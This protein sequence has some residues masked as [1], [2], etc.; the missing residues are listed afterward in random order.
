MQNMLKSLLMKINLFNIFSLNEATKTIKTMFYGIF[1]SSTRM[2]IGATSALYLISHGLTIAEIGYL[3]AVQAFIILATDLP[4]GYL[5]DQYSR[6]LS[7][8]LGVLF[9]ASWLGITA[10]APTKEWFY[11]AEI[12]NALSIALFNGAY[13]AILVETYKKDNNKSDLSALF[14]SYAKYNFLFMAIA[15]AIGSFFSKINSPIFWI[16]GAALLLLQLLFFSDFI[17]NDVKKTNKKRKSIFYFYKKLKK[18]SKRI[19][20]ELF[21]I[22]KLSI[23][24]LINIFLGIYYQIFIQYWQ[25]I[26][27]IWQNE[28]DKST[29]F[30]IIFIGILLI[31]SLAGKVI[32]GIIKIRYSIIIISLLLIINTVVLYLALENKVMIIPICI[33]I[34]FFLIRILS[35]ILSIGINQ[36]LPNE[37]R[38]TFL[39]IDSSLQRLF[40]VIFMPII[41]I[42]ISIKGLI[43]IPILGLFV[44]LVITILNK[45]INDRHNN[46]PTPQKIK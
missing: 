13:Q 9:G 17:E 32:P 39:S 45:K 8:M 40:L 24:F 18:D 1:F 14:S 26:S 31:Q 19:I 37:D 27:R 33:A 15:V 16:I 21:T 41:G 28:T 4:L 23:L 30:G 38:A 43:I 42:L 10:Y 7:V 25:P 5:A 6:K 3:K 12:S 29:I 35:I 11:V 2:L 36:K 20:E 46:N 22:E 44:F 34:F